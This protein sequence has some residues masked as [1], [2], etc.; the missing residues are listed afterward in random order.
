MHKQAP[1]RIEVSE[2]YAKVE[3][4][5]NGIKTERIS[6][7]PALLDIFR[8]VDSSYIS[9]ILPFNCRRHIKKGSNVFVLTYHEEALIKEFKYYEQKVQIPVPRALLLTKLR[10]KGNGKFQFLNASFFALKDPYLNNDELDL[11][12]WP[13]PNQY[14]AFNGDI[15]WGSD[16]TILQFKQEC[17]L[18]NMSA[19]YSI[20]FNAK[21]NDDYGWNID[22]PVADL[23][24]TRMPFD[25]KNQDKFPYAKLKP[26]G[27]KLSALIKLL[28]SMAP[29][30][31]N[32]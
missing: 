3:F 6:D 20:F 7:L 19:V 27:K 8:A 31:A 2:D 28:T 13:F 18:F 10:D 5:N 11:Y 25:L 15:C 9:P 26:T 29:Q 30:A 12:F 4:D 21:G 14:H 17:D 16:P 1:L 32:I 24:G 23:L 22:S